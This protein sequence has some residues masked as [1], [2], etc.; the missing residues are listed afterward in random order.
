[1]A[2][3]FNIF[4]KTLVVEKHVIYVVEEYL[5]SQ[6]STVGLK[7]FFGIQNFL[8]VGGELRAVE[9]EHTIVFDVDSSAS[10]VFLGDETTEKFQKSLGMRLNLVYEDIFSWFC[11]TSQLT[12][13]SLDMFRLVR[14]RSREAVCAD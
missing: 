9:G 2:Y 1:M 8:G 5:D 10:I 12:S 11:S 6:E 3:C 14:H 13:A 4:Y 7:R